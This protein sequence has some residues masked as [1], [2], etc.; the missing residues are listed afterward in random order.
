M[1]SEATTAV[2]NTV[3]PSLIVTVSLGVPV[4]VNTGVLILVLLSVLLP[5]SVVAFRSGAEGTEASTVSVSGPLVWPAGSTWV[6]VSCVPFGNTL[7][8]VTVQ[9]PSGATTAVP[10][11]VPPLMTV[12]V[13]PGSPV[14]V[15]AE[16]L[17][18]AITGADGVVVSIVTA[19]AGLG[20]LVLPAGSVTVVVI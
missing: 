1:P 14:P 2:P 6:A 18:G 5:L 9:L 3:L 4:P 19:N 10:T 11:G 13:D 8:G 16:P 15:M 12:T 17:V 7:E 20:A